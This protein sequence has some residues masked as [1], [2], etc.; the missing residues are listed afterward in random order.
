V[1]PAAG[2]TPAAIDAQ[3]RAANERLPDYARIGAWLPADEPF[4]PKNGLATANG[5]A[6]RERIWQAYRAR[7]DG[8]L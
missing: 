6:R 5:R 1:V 3:V 7:L 4:T 8:V 2:A